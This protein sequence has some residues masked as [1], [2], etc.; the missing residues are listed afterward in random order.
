[1]K[2]YNV[3]VKKLLEELSK[4]SYGS[5]SRI[6]NVFYDE[7]K[8]YVYRALL[9]LHK[10]KTKE[11]II[12]SGISFT[13]KYMALLKCLGE[14]IERLA[15]FNYNERMVLF[16]TFLKLDK[17]ALD[18]S[19]YINI[20]GE[21]FKNKKMGWIYGWNH[22]MQ[23][24]SFIPAQLVYLNYLNKYLKKEGSLTTPISTGAAGGFDHEST[25]LRGIYEVVERDAFMTVYLTRSKV[26]RIDLKSVKNKTIQFIVESYER[27]KLELYAFEITNDIGIPVFLTLVVDKTGFGPSVTIGAKANLNKEKAIIGS[28]E[29]A[30]MIRPW[31]RKEKFSKKPDSIKIQPINIISLINRAKFWYPLERLEKLGF[32]LKQPPRFYN[33]VKT[34]CPKKDEL[35]HV[36]K[37][38]YENGYQIFYADITP[39]SFRKNYLVYKILIPGLQPLYLNERKKEVVQDRL[40]AVSFH[41]GKKKYKINSFP[42]PFL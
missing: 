12:V 23:K 6:D 41:F 29:E 10:T 24:N 26:P 40:K 13:S 1:M 21:S 7:P 25:L 27:Y 9:P 34:P 42:H 17:K 36:T 39:I 20:N 3:L 22:T 38:L 4:R 28:I 31:L 11:Q 35:S 15:L 30:F 5:I 37:I 19:L 32:L 33:K 16:S 2:N 14:W 18:L 8:L